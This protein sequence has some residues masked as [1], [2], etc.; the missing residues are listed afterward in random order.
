MLTSSG[1]RKELCGT[2]ASTF[3]LSLKE[4]FISQHRILFVR[5]LFI[6]KPYALHFPSSSCFV[7]AELMFLFRDGLCLIMK[8]LSFS[9]AVVNTQMLPQ[10]YFYHEVLVSKIKKIQFSINKVNCILELDVQVVL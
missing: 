3:Y 10:V 7:I 2:L 6:S 4:L 8:R 1:P 9:L 5:Q